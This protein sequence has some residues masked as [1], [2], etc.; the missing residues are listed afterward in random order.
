MQALAQGTKEIP[1]FSGNLNATW[2]IETTSSSEK[3]MSSS[4]EIEMVEESQ[5]GDRDDDE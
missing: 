5:R 3:G 1:N 4:Q 2:F